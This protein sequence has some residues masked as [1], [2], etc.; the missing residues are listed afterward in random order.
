MLSVVL[1]VYNEES[2][3]R[4]L[5]EALSKALA[6]AGDWELVFVDDGS[7]DGSPAAL[8]SLAA[9]DNRVRVITLSRNFGNQAAISRGLERA[10]GEWVVTMDSD[11]EDKP[12]DIPALLAKAKEGYDVVYAVRGSSQKTP[13]KHL[14]SVVFYWLLG[15]LAEYPLPRHTGNFAV[16]GRPVVDALNALPER[17]RYLSGLRAWVGFKQAGLPLPRGVRPSGEPK[18]SYARL[19]L[20]AFDAL[21]SFSTVP[22]KMLSFVGFTAFLTSL[23]LAVVV[24]IMRLALPRMDV[25]Y[26]WA[27][28]IIMVIFLGAIQLL[29]LGVLGEY[30]ARI[31]DEVRGRPTSVVRAGAEDDARG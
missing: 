19:F 22:L 13:L 25:P 12:E 26:G 28:T 6:S 5:Y 24:V 21:F 17:H 14:G 20:H 18:Q 30:V 9:A 4:P 8:A 1:P 2:L 23:L 3:V 15:R 10:R 31:Y 27:S 7:R 16:M 11:F 29:G